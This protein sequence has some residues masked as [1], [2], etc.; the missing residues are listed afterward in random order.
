MM[1]SCDFTSFST[2]FQSNQD[3]GLILMNC[4]SQWNQFMVEITP[5]AGLELGMTGNGRV[6]SLEAACL[7]YILFQI[8]MC[9][10]E[11]SVQ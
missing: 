2:V 10:V 11:V 5:R 6:A 8:D 9:I 3:D 1:M 4:H 7:I